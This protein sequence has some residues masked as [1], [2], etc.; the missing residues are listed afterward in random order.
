[1]V[2]TT[3]QPLYPWERHTTPIVQVA[4]WAPGP[5][6]IAAENFAP[7]DLIQAAVSRYTNCDIPAHLTIAGHILSSGA[8]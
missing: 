1:M 5:V 7:W 4:G 2:N 8:G 3:A 6:W